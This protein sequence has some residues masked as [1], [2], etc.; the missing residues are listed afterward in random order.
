MSRIYSREIAITLVFERMVSCDTISETLEKFKEFSERD[1]DDIDFIYVRKLLEIV[2]TN[3]E[4]IETKIDNYSENRKFSRISKINRAILLVAVA[5][6][7]FIQDVPDEVAI[8]EAVEIA[9]N[10]TDYKSC[11]YINGL[12]DKIRLNK[13]DKEEKEEKEETLKVE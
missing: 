7:L 12:L 4:E 6:I 5:E 13:K 8:N 3:K 9:R 11:G 2:D 10:Y 1:L